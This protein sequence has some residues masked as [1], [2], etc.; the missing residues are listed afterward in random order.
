MARPVHSISSL[1]AVEGAKQ[2]SVR[3]LEKQRRGQKSRPCR[4]R[5]REKKTSA[6]RQAAAQEEEP[7]VEGYGVCRSHEIILDQGDYRNTKNLRSGPGLH[8][9]PDHR[10]CNHNGWGSGRESEESD[11][12]FEH[13]LEM[14][15]I[16]RSF[17]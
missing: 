15:C 11:A 14:D 7:E 1:S 2:E 10:R 13:E 8:L 5:G 6:H 4:R 3:T 16:L 12:E 17:V 9:F